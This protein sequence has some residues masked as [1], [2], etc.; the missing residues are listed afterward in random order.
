M[1]NVY[2]HIGVRSQNGASRGLVASALLVCAM[3]AAFPAAGDPLSDLRAVLQRYPAKAPFAASASLQMNSDA[4]GAKGARSGSEIFEVE[5][6]PRGLMIRVPA[7]A[8][9]V[10]ETEAENR[11]RDLTP[12]RTA[13]VALTIFDVID[14]MNAA[15]MLLND[16]DSATLIDQTSSARAGKPATLLRIKVKPTL[17]DASSRFLNEPKIELRVWIDSSGTPLAAERD[18]SYSA[19]FLL[20]LKA[21]NI[22]KERWE[23]VVSGDRLYA[24]RNDEDDRAFAVGKSIATSRSVTYL[25]K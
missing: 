19:S 12:T 8:L 7:A 13:M 15:A 11:R 22:R 14:A 20:F 9:G 10:A 23:L 2:T 6:G 16:L 24:S 4:Q 3:L 1:L 21:G 17:A 18:S 5:F 25:P